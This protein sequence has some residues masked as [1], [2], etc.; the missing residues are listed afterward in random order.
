MDSSF[1]K[2]KKNM[3]GTNYFYFRSYILICK[4]KKEVSAYFTSK[5]IL[6]IRF[7]RHHTHFVWRHKVIHCAHSQP[8]SSGHANELRPC[9]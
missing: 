6:P 1:D 4:A 8:Q 2:F 5:Q 3:V 9:D 7:A